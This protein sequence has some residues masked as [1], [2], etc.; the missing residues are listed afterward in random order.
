MAAL[1]SAYTDNGY[2]VIGVA[3]A[4]K[5]ADNLTEESNIPSFTVAKLITDHQNGRNH[6]SNANVLVIDE[7]GQLGTKQLHE[8]LQ[9][10][11]EHSVKV[12]LVG[13][14]KQLDAIEHGGCLRFL[15]QKLGCSR[16]EKI[17]RQ[18]KEWARTAVMQLRDGKATQAME[19]FKQKGLLHFR[20]RRVF[21]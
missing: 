2:S 18:R 13:E 6:F 11:S 19:T 21:R 9:L 5:A 20:F 17:Q 14:D 7:A 12:I 10:A 15:S 8:L 4:K 1:Y 3:I 16:I